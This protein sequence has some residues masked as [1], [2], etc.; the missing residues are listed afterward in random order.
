MADEMSTFMHSALSSDFSMSVDDVTS[1]CDNT[2]GSFGRFQAL[3]NGDTA[4]IKKVLQA[5]HD[6]GMSPAFFASYEANESYNPSWGWLNYT[7]PQGDVVQDA[8]FVAKH[9]V[10]VSQNMSGSP[11]WIDAGNPVDFVP[12]SV[13]DSGNADFQSMPSGT[14]GRA[15]IPST[16]AATWEVYYPNGLLKSYNQVQ[17]YG[18]PMTAC[19]KVIKAWGGKIDGGTPDPNPDP[20][21]DPTPPNPNPDPIPTTS[22]NKIYQLF[23]NSTYQLGG[24]DHLLRFNQSLYH[25]VTS[26]D[27]GGGDNPPTPDPD[28]NPPNPNPDPNPTLDLAWLDSIHGQ[29]VGGSDQCYGLASAWAMHNGTPQLIGGSRQAGIEVA[30]PSLPVSMGACNIGCEY[31]WES[32]GW[33]VI[34][35]PKLEDIKAGDICCMVCDDAG[36]IPAV[37]GVRYGHVCIAGTNSGGV[38]S[39]WEQNGVSRQ[40]GNYG[41]AKQPQDHGAPDFGKNYIQW[42]FYAIRKKA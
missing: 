38:F 2:T 39:L 34:V 5:V 32:W 17:D 22:K 21:P 29:Q 8:S 36:W 13:K 37:D 35:H 24:S 19:I 41:V 15:Y 6:A 9:M 3:C 18:A 25:K 27:G 16:A 11:S 26:S 42:C 33:E 30:E 28:P 4:T 23:P 7:T 10:E 12:Q 40:D 14:I 20:N 31:P 1:H